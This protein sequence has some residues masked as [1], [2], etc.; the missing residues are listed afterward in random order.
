MKRIFIAAILALICGGCG[1]SSPSSNPYYGIG[2]SFGETSAVNSYISQS[3]LGSNAQ[4][5]AVVLQLCQQLETNGELSGINDGP[6][7]ADQLAWA[8]GCAASYPLSS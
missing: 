7:T 3:L 4:T 5:S 2:Y 8:K 6:T 1:S